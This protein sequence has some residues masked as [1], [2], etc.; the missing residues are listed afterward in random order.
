M[1]VPLQ[2]F[3]VQCLNRQPPASRARRKHMQAWI[4][5]ETLEPYSALQLALWQPL[6]LRDIQ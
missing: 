6:L 1:T 2:A 4:R 5:A 3:R